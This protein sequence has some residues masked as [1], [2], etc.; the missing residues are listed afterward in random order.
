MNDAL[1]AAQYAAMYLMLFRFPVAF[2][3][4]WSFILFS[5]HSVF[6]M[7]YN[8]QECGFAMTEMRYQ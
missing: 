6:I 5:P 3:Q 1:V 4:W 2:F 8:D 7:E